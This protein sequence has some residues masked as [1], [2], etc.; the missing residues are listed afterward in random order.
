M[1]LLDTVTLKVTSIHPNWLNGWLGRKLSSS[2]LVDSTLAAWTAHLKYIPGVRVNLVD[3]V[4]E[5]REIVILL[6]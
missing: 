5:L 6:D 1:E 2:Q 4:T 3:W